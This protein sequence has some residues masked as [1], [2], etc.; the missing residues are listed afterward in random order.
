M[1]E[2]TPL[3]SVSISPRNH[4]LNACVLPATDIPPTPS[5][6]NIKFARNQAVSI[7]PRPIY[8]PAIVNASEAIFGKHPDDLTHEEVNKFTVYRRQQ[9][10]I[11][12]PL[13]EQTI[14][15]PSGGMRSCVNCGELT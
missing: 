8:H 2:I 14:Y 13:E 3:Q 5:K 4:E 7:P 10:H 15:L 9:R 12:E 6:S 1:S 11:G